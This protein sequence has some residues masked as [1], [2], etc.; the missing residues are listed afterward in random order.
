MHATIFAKVDQ[1]ISNLLGKESDALKSATQNIISQNIADASISSNQGKLLQVFA[2]ACNAKRILELGTLGAYS[3]IW[4][5]NALPDDGKIITIELDEHH[6]KV[7]LKNIENAGLS[8]KIDLRI[9]KAQEIVSN[10]V[11]VRAEPFD[12]IFIDADKPP[13]T[14][15]F[16]LALQ[17][18]RSGTII[19]CDNV[20]RNGKVLDK[21]SSDE[22]VLGVQRL[23]AFLSECKEVTATVLQTVG[24]KEYDGMVIAVVN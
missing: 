16:K 10:L 15:Y 20:I 13:Y 1:Y 9:G 24:V 8:G 18:S 4:L 17:L 23:I 5:A 2:K 6:A 14:E 3:T 19:I 7:A 22:K 21:N 11:E 12:M